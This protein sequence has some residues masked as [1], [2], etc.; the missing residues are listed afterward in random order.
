MASPLVDQSQTSAPNHANGRPHASASTAGLPRAGSSA[1]ARLTAH[2]TQRVDLGARDTSESCE[3]DVCLLRSLRPFWPA[4]QSGEE[5]AGRRP[6]GL[7]CGSV[8]VTGS[9]RSSCIPMV[10]RLAKTVITTLTDDIDGAT[11]DVATYRF[12]WL[13]RDYEVDLSAK[14]FKAF[15]AAIAPYVQAGRIQPRGTTTKTSKST[16]REYDLPALREWAASQAIE[17]PQRG[18]SPKP[19]SPSTWRGSPITVKRRANASSRRS[20]TRVPAPARRH[21]RTPRSGV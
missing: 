6:H 19:S 10:A 8:D 12:G 13:G 7:R 18:A 3:G 15:D 9:E 17:L 11:K 21:S 2:W 4:P 14:N 16:D 1:D 5:S 20:R